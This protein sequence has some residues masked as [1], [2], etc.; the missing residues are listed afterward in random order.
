MW[1]GGGTKIKGYHWYATDTSSWNLITDKPITS[2]SEIV[3]S[4]GQ[5]IWTITD[6][7]IDFTKGYFYA[8]TTGISTDS[9][10]DLYQA[11]QYKNIQVINKHTLQ[12]KQTSINLFGFIELQ[13][14]DIGM[15]D[16]SRQDTL[17]MHI[18]RFPSSPSDDRTECNFSYD[19]IT[20]A[21]DRNI[22]NDVYVHYT[23]QNFNVQP[24][25]NGVWVTE[26]LIRGTS[27]HFTATD[28]I[29]KKIAGIINPVKDDSWDL[30]IITSAGL[31]RPSGQL[32]FYFVNGKFVKI[33][34]N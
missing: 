20:Y 31:T 23:S 1:G 22:A 4:S 11:E 6:N 13:S 19:R 12:Y 16:L 30:S 21:K 32:N 34:N 2:Y 26:F 18:M 27:P 3:S 15:K 25:P 10:F 8:P 33:N 24:S 17:D 14:G 29:P 9:Y 7:D 5:S 28:I